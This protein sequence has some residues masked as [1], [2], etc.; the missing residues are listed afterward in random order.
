MTMRMSTL[1]EETV[2]YFSRFRTKPADWS[3]Q[4]L[5][6]F[7]RVE[8]ALSQAGFPV[9]FDRGLTDEGDPWC[10]FC[11][12]DTGDVVV[13]FARIDGRCVVASPTLGVSL[14]GTSFQEVVRQFLSSLPA[15]T[16]RQRF[17][18]DGQLF[19]HPAAMIVALVATAFCASGPAIQDGQEL[20]GT[21]N[22]ASA[23]SKVI[24]A[25]RVQLA[26]LQNDGSI[27]RDN[28][29]KVG[30]L[31]A[32]VV[33]LEFSVTRSDERVMAL[34][35]ADQAPTTTSAHSPMSG[36]DVD[37]VVDLAEAVLRNERPLE[38]SLASFAEFPSEN[39]LLQALA[40]K[41][42]KT[43][44]SADVPV[45]VPS[46]IVTASAQEAYGNGDRMP[47]SVPI[48]MDSPPHLT[49]GKSAPL[50]PQETHGTQTVQ[51]AEKLVIFLNELEIKYFSKSDALEVRDAKE[52]STSILASSTGP[53]SVDIGTTVTHPAVSTSPQ[54]DSD[55]PLSMVTA[56]V[57]ND[58]AQQL[59]FAFIK[60]DDDIKFIQQGSAMVIFDSSDIMSSTLTLDVKS[61]AFGAE[62]TISIVGA[63]STLDSIL[64]LHT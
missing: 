32:I 37:A 16:P 39:D 13:H 52:L 4:D 43:P 42:A 62:G 8:S 30:I 55:L 22:E 48:Q 54:G 35:I 36:F 28:L 47:M 60:S 49:A 38:V 44:A 34:D 33:A 56:P 6:E 11:R 21:R 45:E 26:A 1:R 53:A 3:N 57:F 31:T 10:A 64:A 14:E 17:G 12:A 58:S 20:A 63:S 5:A 27:F 7:Y 51:V 25:I 50:T 46:S 15:V 19:L 9:E 29:V 40:D 18:R 61:W 41:P 2:L 59:V 23:I 24:D